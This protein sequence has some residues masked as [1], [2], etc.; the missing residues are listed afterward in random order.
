MHRKIAVVYDCNIYITSVL[1]TGV[2]FDIDLLKR[3]QPRKPYM[4]S[5]RLKALLWG[6]KAKV[7]ESTLHVGWSDHIWNTVSYELRTQFDWEDEDI[8]Q[9]I[10]TLQTQ[11]IEHSHGFTVHPVSSGY[12]KMGDN[13]DSHVYETCRSIAANGWEVLLVTDDFPFIIEV[14]ARHKAIDCTPVERHIS[15]LS[16][17]DFCSLCDVISH[18]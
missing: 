1:A 10:Q 15:A 13:E 6:F 18:M 2:P 7:G 17:E 16:A 4:E 3:L 5:C 12:V 8:T 9:Y 11:L 14:E